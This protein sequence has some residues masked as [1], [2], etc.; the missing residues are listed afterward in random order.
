MRDE[1]LS[2]STP[3]KPRVLLVED[4]AIV[5]E[6]LA[7]VLSDEYEVETAGN[8]REALTAVIRSLPALIVT[9]IV[10]PDIDGLELLRTL[11]STR[12]TQAIPVLLISGRAIDEQR[13]EGFKLGADGYLSKPYAERELRTRIGS[14]LRSARVRNEAIRREALEQAEK[15]A[16]AERAALLESITDAFYALDHK[17]RFTYLNRRALDHFGKPANEM[18]GRVLWDV[19]P[20]MRGSV[21]QQQYERAMDDQCAVAF[22]AISVV[23]GAWVDV[24]AYPTPQG[25][26]AYFRDIS[27]RKRAEEQLR[28]ADRRKGEFL[29]ILAHELRNPLAPL[30]NGLQ[31]LKRSVTDLPGSQTVGMMDRQL[32]HLV[33]LVDD[34]LDLNRITSGK[35]ALR[36]QRILLADTLRGALESS[37]SLIERH[38]HE[39]M[40]D[41]QAPDVAVDGDRDRLAQILSNLLTNS[42][43]YTDPGGR[44]L[45]TLEREHGEAVLSVEDNGIGIAPGEL[46]SIFEMFSQAQSSGAR[47]TEGLGIGLSLVRTL[48]QMHGGTVRAFSEGPGTGSRFVVR[49]PIAQSGLDVRPPAGPSAYSQ[50][51]GHRVL[52]VDDNADSATSLALLL[53][54]EECVV[55]TAGDGEEAIQQVQSFH[56][57][58]VFMDIGMPRLDGVEAT[59]RIRALPEGN[60]LCIVALTGH[61]QPAD[62]QRTREAG[63]DHHVVKPMTLELLQDLLRYGAEASL[64]AERGAFRC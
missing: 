63:M 25:L 58:I 41:V 21:F 49:L 6:H 1:D 11:R 30:R 19:I 64:S 45:V 48:V 44:I 46:E 34:L 12:R 27:A 13:I 31:L 28:E 17:L 54:M 2:R 8:G 56:P 47:V 39:L 23:S 16:L 57:T 51:R 60:R 22:E 42:A 20:A 26:A 7:R 37:R 43:K 52:V 36:R 61:G 10:M 53:E 50:E 38:H 62:R 5:R 40:V 3:T 59:R 24:R 33:R 32:T 18:L 9:D 14:M 35:L 4:E 55:Q 15:K 29:A